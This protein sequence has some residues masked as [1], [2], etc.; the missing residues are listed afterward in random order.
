MPQMGGRAG[1][2][3]GPVAVAIGIVAIAA[4]PATLVA[5]AIA[6][7][8]TCAETGAGAPLPI[9]VPPCSDVLAQ[10]PRWL[11]AITAGDVATIESI[12]APTYRHV[13]GDG[14]MLDRA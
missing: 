5:P 7:A 13:N 14:Q 11:E 3:I 6:R 9:E 1:T 4:F 8:D 10:E 2:G 12:L